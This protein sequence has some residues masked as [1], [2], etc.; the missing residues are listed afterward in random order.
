LCARVRRVRLV[1]WVYGFFIAN[2]LLFATGFARDPGNVWLARAFY[3]WVSVFNLFVVS[4]AWSVMADA[5]RPGQAQ[6]LFPP[7]AAGASTGGL[8]GPLAGAA[9]VPHVGLA[10]LAAVLLVVTLGLVT[11]TF[12]WRARFG[13]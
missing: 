2:L 4:L 8:V 11:L 6:R 10:V 3:V 5:L 1:P 7:I 13:A 9:L 12:R